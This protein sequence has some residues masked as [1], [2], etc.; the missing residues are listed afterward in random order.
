MRR[1][2]CSG[3]YIAWVLSA[4]HFVL[5][6]ALTSYAADIQSKGWTIVGLILVVIGLIL[7]VLT[8]ILIHVNLR[9]RISKTPDYQGM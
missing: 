7:M 5:G 1:K 8:S 2:R 4:V 3:H 6:V 9:E